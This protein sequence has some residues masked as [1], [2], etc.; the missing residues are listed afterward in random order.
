[1]SSITDVL[2]A[3]ISRSGKRQIERQIG[4]DAQSTSRAIPA[5]IATLV[6]A[7]ARNSSRQGGAGDLLDALQRDHDGTILENL[8]DVLTRPDRAAGD[9]ILGHVLGNER[10]RLEH[11]LGKAVGLDS[12]SMANLFAMLAPIVMGALGKAQQRGRLDAGSLASILGRERQAASK[13]MPANLGV[14]GSL[15]DR[16]GDGSIGDDVAE[17]SGSLVADFL[18]HR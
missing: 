3:Q 16:D 2:T 17:I 12:D 18:S 15:L 14:L 11:R 6:S 10:R 8:D 9:A 1:M 13:R 4:A 5:A 7:L